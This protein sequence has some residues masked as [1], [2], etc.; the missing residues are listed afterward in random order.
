MHLVQSTLLFTWHFE[1]RSTSQKLSDYEKPVLHVLQGPDDVSSNAY[2]WT[3]IASRGT[4]YSYNTKLS[5]TME[6]PEPGSCFRSP[7]MRA[8][9]TDSSL[10]SSQ[11][12]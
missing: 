9:E 1:V 12:P 2:Y 10:D 4:S 8:P 11:A 5:S 6:A 3:G 7:D